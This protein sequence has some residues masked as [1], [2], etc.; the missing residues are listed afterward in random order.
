VEDNVQRAVAALIAFDDHLADRIIAEDMEVDQLEV[1]IEEECLK[2]LALYQPV[3]N[4]LRFVIAVLKIN[5]DLER[6][7]DEAVNIAERAL[8]LAHHERVEVNFDFVAM[9]T[10]AQAMLRNSLDALVACDS[11]QARGVGMA[12]DEVDELNRQAYVHIQR[13]IKHHPEKV[14]QFVHYLT[15]SRHLER[16]ADYATNIAEDVVYMIDG[17]VI[18][19]KSEDF[20]N[21][22]DATEEIDKG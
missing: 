18:R 20:N 3:A 12:D 9:A 19:H 10:K 21:G 1:D 15:V 22:D 11:Q 8:F 7:G 2:I 16:I 13:A 5:N 4:D 6:I 14:A 17:E